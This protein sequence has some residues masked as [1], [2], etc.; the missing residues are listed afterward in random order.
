MNSTLKTCPDASRLAAWI[1]GRASAEERQA[2]LAHSLTCPACSELV[3]DVLAA[4]RQ[5][6]AQERGRPIFRRAWAAAAALLVA[7]TGSFAFWLSRDVGADSYRQALAA[8]LQPS[9]AATAALNFHPPSSVST[10]GLPQ[11]RVLRGG[12]ESGPC[13]PQT[14]CGE[15]L[16]KALDR[17]GSPLRLKLDPEAAQIF[18]ASSA[19]DPEMAYAARSTIEEHGWATSG[20]PRLR[21]AACLVLALTRTDHRR[22]IEAT[23]SAVDPSELEDL[24]ALYN[25]AQLAAHVGDLDREC[26]ALRAYLARAPASA[27]RDEAQRRSARCPLP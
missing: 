20:N 2:L 14:P 15:A 24:A 25:L 27:W 26:R 17:A 9:A 21:V 19:L 8:A 11:P 4:Q 13:A 1:D 16:E 22:E 12:P 5:T 6:T 7:G 23:V 3:A 18:L 10:A